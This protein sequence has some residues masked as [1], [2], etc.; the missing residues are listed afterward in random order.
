MATSR[1]R[2][3]LAGSP[4]RALVAAGEKVLAGERL[5][6]DDGLALSESDDLLRVG[7]LANLVRERKNGNVG[8]YI[9][10]RYLNPTNVCWVDC[11]LCAW[12]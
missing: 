4:N 6:F 2:R 11:Q 1:I 10:N 7:A 12:A 3:I 5:T 8:Y 9:V